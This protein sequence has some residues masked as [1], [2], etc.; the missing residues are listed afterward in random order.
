MADELADT[1]QNVVVGFDTEL[2]DGDH[3]LDPSPRPTS[4]GG[5]IASA[6]QLPQV[7]RANPNGPTGAWTAGVQSDATQDSSVKRTSRTSPSNPKTGTAQNHTY[8]YQVQS[9]VSDDTRI[10]SGPIINPVA[11]DNAKSLA[12]TSSSRRSISLVAPKD[13]T[14]DVSQ[15]P[16]TSSSRRSIS[17]VPRKN[18]SGHVTQPPGTQSPA[19]KPKTSILQ[20]SSRGPNSSSKSGETAL[21]KQLDTLQREYDTLAKAVLASQAR[22][23]EENRLRR[24]KDKRHSKGKMR[25]MKAVKRVIHA[26]GDDGVGSSNMRKRSNSIVMREAP[27]FFTGTLDDGAATNE[28]A[29]D[30]QPGILKQQKSTGALRSD[31]RRSIPDPASA[32]AGRRKTMLQKLNGKF[33]SQKSLTDEPDAASVPVA[34]KNRRFT[35]LSNDKLGLESTET[36]NTKA[37]SKVVPRKSVVAD[38]DDNG[39]TFMIMDDD[40][41]DDD[42]VD[43]GGG[44]NTPMPK[45]TSAAVAPTDDGEAVDQP[46][47]PRKVKQRSRW[48][49]WSRCMPIIHPRSKFRQRWNLLILLLLTYY[50]FVLPFRVGFGV[51]TVGVLFVVE[52]LFDITF[53]VDL[54]LNFFTGYYEAGVSM[55]LLVLNR[56]MIAKRYLRS[57]FALDFVSAFPVDLVL[58]LMRDDWDIS[59]FKLGR[60]LRMLKLF[61]LLRIL[62]LNR[63]MHSV[64]SKMKPGVARSK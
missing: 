29:A 59:A 49:A 63:Y 11:T 9:L 3:L 42:E 47:A 44:G 10:D 15:T 37:S 35:V 12:R 61:R 60:L 54:Y 7:T 28:N 57:W 22:I 1:S 4:G 48:L 51:D 55:D 17:L 50:T 8:Q 26:G 25:F 24:G 18:S 6:K 34:S 36:T 33:N 14:G 40:D 19:S 38:P 53:L 2:S 5:R 23:R 32:A 41:D 62:G 27:S 39:Y 16:R 13:S 64:L 21:R 56:N 46:V 31:R 58:F 43:G 52:T 20:S 45:A 30:R